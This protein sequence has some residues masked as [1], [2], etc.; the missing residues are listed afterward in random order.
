L[1]SIH[2]IASEYPQITNVAN[3]NT[4]SLNGKWRTIVDQAEIG[5]KRKF[6]ED[7]SVKDKTEL[8]EY[9]FDMAEC[10]NVPGDWNSQRND[11]V[12]YEGK[13]W[14]RNKFSFSPKHN[15]RY[16][17]YFGAANYK[18]EVYLNGAKLGE[19][20]GGFTPFNFEITNFLKETNSLVV[21]VDNTRE[22]EQIPTII[23]DWKN[24]GGIT[25]EVLVIEEEE[26]FIRDY[27]LQ[28]KKGRAD[29]VSFK[30]WLSDSLA[31][32]IVQLNIP[33]LN[34][35]EKIAIVNGFAQKEI[36]AKIPEFWSPEKPKLYEVV[37]S[38]NNS[39]LKEK[40]G[41]RTI[42]VKGPDILLNGK[43]IFL[44]GISLHEENPFTAGRAHSMEEARMM[45]T[46]AQEL[47]C[48]YVRL[49]HY[50]H[51]ENVVRLA[52][53]MG[54]LLW[55]EI[56]VYW[57]IDWDN[58]ETYR[59]A[60]SMLS[61]LIAR[62]KNRASVIIW[63]VANETDISES[64]NR[65]LKGLIDFTRENDHCRLVSAALLTETEVEVEKSI[66]TVDDPF[67]NYADIISVN[68]YLGWYGRHTPS[69]LDK[70]E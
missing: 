2:A 34:I 52:D 26:L 44:K 20:K 31:N 39:R 69:M 43:S 16:F 41:F 68:Q 54:V 70:L 64:R 19:H 12:N 62:D 35:Q 60:K 56:P 7:K 37:L 23:S 46:W 59:L 47:G 4:V 67:G 24:F 48:N 53:E 27:Y 63:S 9:N 40:I 15:K 5:N 14:Y 1:L 33:E 17:L 32:G 38:V 65:F 57:Q 58:E 49:S 50:P 29:I 6:W 55:E 10:L 13:I 21:S 36:K 28:L 66:K 11:L 51:N 61:D 25:R 8:L 18:T 30:A 3:R 42:E 45:L 22:K